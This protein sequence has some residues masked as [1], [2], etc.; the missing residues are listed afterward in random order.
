MQ[1]PSGFETCGIIVY[2][3]LEGRLHSHSLKIKHFATYQALKKKL[4]RKVLH[5]QNNRT[6]V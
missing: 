5:F 2:V 6:H 1:V 3:H 4:R